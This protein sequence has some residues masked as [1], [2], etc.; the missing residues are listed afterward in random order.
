MNWISKCLAT[1]IA[2]NIP[3]NVIVIDNGSSDGTQSFISSFDKEIYLV[4]NKENL[5]FGK[6]NN[7]GIELAIKNKADYIFLLNQDAYLNPDTIQNLINTHI[8]YP[9]YGVLS[10]IQMNGDGTSQDK[11]FEY[12]L[13]DRNNCFGLLQSDIINGNKEVYRVKFVMAAL[14]LVSSTCIKKIGMFDPIFSHYGEDNDFLNRA[15]F[16]GFYIG[17]VVNA[18]GY[19]DRHQRNESAVKR[20]EINYAALLA[21]A[22]NVNQPFLVSF[23]E[24]V[25]YYLK[26]SFKY[27]FEVKIKLLIQNQNEFTKLI[28]KIPLI[29][30]SRKNNIKPHINLS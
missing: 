14:W 16:H 5:G 19:H 10:P 7:I 29:L 18:I 27:L 22:T 30:K 17:I 20:I 23:S 26:F 1:I 24:V 28:L 3:I 15:H 8:N 6:A 25:Y 9:N 21:R 2:S 13:N 11:N 12:L 4:E